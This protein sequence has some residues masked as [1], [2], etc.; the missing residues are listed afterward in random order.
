MW[1]VGYYTSPNLFLKEAV[2]AKQAKSNKNGICEIETDR[3][4]LLN[5]GQRTVRVING[6]A[7]AYD[8]NLGGGAVR[9]SCIMLN[10]AIFN[11]NPQVHG[12]HANYYGVGVLRK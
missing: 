7:T 3:I 6:N 4:M 8:W 5:R 9:N 10:N 11:I 1:T 12:F 2:L